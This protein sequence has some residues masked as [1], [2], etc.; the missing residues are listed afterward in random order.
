MLWGK[1]G[2]I[3][4]SHVTFSVFL[5]WL[6]DTE[7]YICLFDNRFCD[8]VSS[9]TAYDGREYGWDPCKL[10][11]ELA[12]GCDPSWIK[13]LGCCKHGKTF[14]GCSVIWSVVVCEINNLLLWLLY[15]I[16]GV[17]CEGSWLWS[18]D[19]SIPTMHCAGCVIF[20]TYYICR[21]VYW[22]VL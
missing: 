7:V 3:L 6:I 4:I 5:Q 12:N 2:R 18:K 9:W 15:T 14:L 16:A 20:Y 1:Q 11:Q 8:F 17:W 10:C 19:L 21:S 13:V 22:K